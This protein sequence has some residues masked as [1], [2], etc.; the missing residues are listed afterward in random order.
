LRHPRYT[1]YRNSR[2]KGTHAYNALKQGL[3][4][5]LTEI[6]W[7]D[8]LPLVDDPALRD[9]IEGEYASQPPLPP[10]WMPHP[11]ERRYASMAEVMR[12]LSVVGNVRNLYAAFFLGDVEK[13]TGPISLAVTG[14]PR[15]PLSAADVAALV[16]RAQRPARGRAAAAAGQAVRRRATRDDL[17]GGPRVIATRS[18]YFVPGS[19]AGD[20]ADGGEG[21]AAA[22][23]L[24]ARDKVPADDSGKD[25]PGGLNVVL[26]PRRPGLACRAA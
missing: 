12:L 25:G 7:S 22:R 17:R 13:I 6:V 23:W 3:V 21:L 9:V 24:P 10:N 20:A 11:G 1:I 26:Q 14:S 18:G 19:R 5:L 2:G 16:T 8:I 15:P 4:S